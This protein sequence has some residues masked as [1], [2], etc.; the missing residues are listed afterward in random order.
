MSFTA[1]QQAISICFSVISFL[2][3][4]I[5]IP[6]A[7]GRWHQWKKDMDEWKGEI[8]EWKIEVEKWKNETSEKINK[9]FY[10]IEDVRKSIENLT[11]IIN[12]LYT[13][14]GTP[15]YITRSVCEKNMEVIAEKIK[16]SNENLIEKINGLKSSID[17]NSIFDVKD[18]FQSMQ[19]ILGII[20]NK[21]EKKEN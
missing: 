5:G 8:N 17:R 15:S 3:V 1:F 7:W 14:D 20:L 2:A 6:I 16:T 18:D 13:E 9:D 11:K 4:F 19:S 10:G 12:R 21:L